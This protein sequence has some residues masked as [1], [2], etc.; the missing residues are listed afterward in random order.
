M[1]QD[2]KN[3]IFNRISTIVFIASQ[4]YWLFWIGWGIY[5]AITGVYDNMFPSIYEGHMIYG[6]KTIG[7][8]I[9]NMFLVTTE[10]PFILIPIYQVVFCLTSLVK[11]LQRWYKER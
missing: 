11:K 7:W 9:L 5:Y 1:K 10:T 2:K 6:T 8:T 3:N 4:L